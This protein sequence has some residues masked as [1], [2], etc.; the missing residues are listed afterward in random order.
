MF[1]HTSPRTHFLVKFRDLDGQFHIKETFDGKWENI[2]T[3]KDE[4]DICLDTF[5][6]NQRGYQKIT[7]NIEVDE[8]GTINRNHFSITDSY[9]AYK[10]MK[11]WK[12]VK[13]NFDP[14][15][16]HPQELHL[17]SV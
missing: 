13:H 17:L 4:D 10:E 11:E 6:T 2:I 7:C 15:S 8:V 5:V 9:T 1:I 12:W 3:L 16:F 14:H